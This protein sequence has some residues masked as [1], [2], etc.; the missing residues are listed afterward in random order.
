M[1]KRIIFLLIL[2]LLL[3][4][5]PIKANASEKNR[6]WIGDSRTV[7]LEQ[8]INNPIDKFIA[9]GGMSLS[10]FENT[11]IPELK[12]NINNNS[13]VFINMGVNDCANEAVGGNS[14][15]TERY[16]EL[17]NNLIIEYPNV[18]FYYISVN[19]VDGDYPSDYSETGY[20]DKNKLNNAINKFNE[21]IKE[22]C[23][24]KYIDTNT[25]LYKIN[26]QTTDGIHYDS[27]I[28]NKIYDYCLEEINKVEIVNKN[29]NNEIIK[30]KEKQFENLQLIKEKK[31]FVKFKEFINYTVD[32]T[33]IIYYD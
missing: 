11:A 4:L 31:K 17:V 15:Y 25:Y 28:T 21:N 24:A 23:N 30:Y 7:A 18:E 14:S 33:G 29:E 10:W 1:K 19:P 8:I 12:K 26:F 27:N 6:I 32:K 16:I 3:T 22:K 20:I 5:V 9:K 2:S 13:I